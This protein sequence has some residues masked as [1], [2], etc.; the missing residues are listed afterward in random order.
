[1]RKPF[2]AALLMSSAI[3]SLAQQDSNDHK[4]GLRLP[5]QKG[6]FLLGSNLVYGG[7]EM[8][9]NSQNHS[10]VS[11]YNAGLN[12][13]AGYFIKNNLMVGAELSSNFYG[14]VGERYQINQQ[15]QSVGG[16][17]FV[18]KYFGSATERDGSL[19]R[20]RFFVEG[21]V[22]Y[23]RTWNSYNERFE[24]ANH[25]SMNQTSFSIMPGVNYFITKNVALEAGLRYTH[26]LPIEYDF[27][28]R[29]QAYV[30]VVWYLGRKK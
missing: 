23:Q 15:T 13:K 5:T 21:S 28:D 1:M 7:V 27:P 12:V 22:N 19:T 16:S 26:S 11:S 10:Y 2:I 14:N 8:A 18:R 30:G 25:W 29:L 17:L 9:R 3:P 24:P 4:I 20:L 6:T